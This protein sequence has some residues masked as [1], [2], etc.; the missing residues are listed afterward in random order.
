MSPKRK[1]AEE[2]NVDDDSDGPMQGSSLSKIPRPSGG[3]DVKENRTEDRKEDQKLSAEDEAKALLVRLKQTC[4]R[5]SKI[6]IDTATPIAI[7]HQMAKAFMAHIQ[8]EGADSTVSDERTASLFRLFC[9]PVPIV[10]VLD[11]A[12]VSEF[13][14]AIILREAFLTAQSVV[15][16]KSKL[17]N[18]PEP[19]QVGPFLSKWLQRKGSLG[20]FC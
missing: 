4:G 3:L 16:R 19:N 2:S 13:N 20:F 14:F 10:N 6:F 5:C 8:L 1:L 15:T 12:S 7:A 11:V 9:P 18:W 17:V